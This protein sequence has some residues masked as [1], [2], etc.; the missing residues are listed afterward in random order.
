MR[1][2]RR[3][4]IVV[5][6]AV[7]STLEAFAFGWRLLCLLVTRSIGLLEHFREYTGF[8]LAC[9]SSRFGRLCATTRYHRSFIGLFSSLGELSVSTCFGFRLPLDS[10]R[11]HLP[12]FDMLGCRPEG[13]C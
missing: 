6:I 4:P 12:V 9:A 8:P 5:R 10:V 7:V 13:E 11:F 2:F 1:H 3:L